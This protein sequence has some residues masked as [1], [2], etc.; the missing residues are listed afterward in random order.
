MYNRYS[1]YMFVNTIMYIIY[2]FLYSYL[3]NDL[4]S[5]RRAV[6]HL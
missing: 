4:E 1:V 3:T 6:Q 5:N 2:K